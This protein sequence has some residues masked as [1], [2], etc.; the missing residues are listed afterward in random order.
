MLLP[1]LVRRD[2]SS[3]S[4]TASEDDFKGVLHDLNARVAELR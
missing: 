2:R 4:A 3:R 1:E